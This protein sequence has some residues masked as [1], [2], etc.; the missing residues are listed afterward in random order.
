MVVNKPL[1]RPYSLGGWALGGGVPLDSHDEGCLQRR[2]FQSI[3]THLSPRFSVANPSIELSITGCNLQGSASCFS[4]SCLLCLVLE[5]KGQTC[6][7]PQKTNITMGK[8][9]NLKMYLLLKMMIFQ[10]VMLVFRGVYPICQSQSY[11]NDI[12]FFPRVRSGV[13]SYSNHPKTMG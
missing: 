7:T 11:L 4:A 1:I 6:Q 10:P 3:Q 2:D 5:T 12:T 8:T 9:T 13:F